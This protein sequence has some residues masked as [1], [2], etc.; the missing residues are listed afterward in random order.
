MLI[1]KGIKHQDVKA[2]VTSNFKDAQTCFLGE[3]PDFIYY[4]EYWKQ[5]STSQRDFI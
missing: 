4:I 1:H 2:L 3:I 5:K